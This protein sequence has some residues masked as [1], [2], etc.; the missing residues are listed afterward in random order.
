MNADT[1]ARAFE[2]VQG[3]SLDDLRDALLASAVR[4]AHL[5]VQWE[6]AEPAQRRE[7]DE[8]RTR[9][10]NVFIDDCNILARNQV[11]AGEDARWRNLLGEDRRDI[12]DFACHIHLLLGL[13]AR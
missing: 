8:S 9:A 12:G 13:R 7:I 1:A 4:Y 6:L 3:S 11:K 5:R 2:A 10:H